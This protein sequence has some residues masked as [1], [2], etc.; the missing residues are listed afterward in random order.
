MNWN[1]AVKAHIVDVHCHPTDARVVD[2]DVASQ[3]NITI[4]AQ[5]SHFADQD[6]VAQLARTC[7]DQ[8]IPCFGSSDW[9]LK[10]AKISVP[11]IQAII[12]G[13]PT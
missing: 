2:Y 7:P 3:L 10:P 12:L 1:P 11:V 5:S 6:K 8:V 4:C 9:C 13:S